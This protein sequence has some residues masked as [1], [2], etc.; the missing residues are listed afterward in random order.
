VRDRLP[1]GHFAWFVIEAVPNAA[2]AVLL[3]PR[4]AMFD[5]W[6]WR[7]IRQVAEQTGTRQADRPS[8]GG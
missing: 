6:N 7:A 2:P 3:W 5:S 8:A 4:A 1:E